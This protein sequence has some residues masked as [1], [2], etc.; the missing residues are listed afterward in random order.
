VLA[1][2]NVGTP[3][4]AGF[5]LEIRVGRSAENAWS[6]WLYM[7]DWGTPPEG[8]R[9]VRFERGRVDID[10]FRSDTLFDRVQYR[11]RATT[12]GPPGMLHLRRVTLCLSDLKTGGPVDAPAAA[13]PLQP[14]AWQRR[15]PVPFRTQKTDQPELAGK[16]CSPTSVA[17]VMAYYGV[18]RSTLDVAQACLDPHHGIYGNWPRNVQ[19]AYSFGVPGYLARFTNW[20][21]VERAIADGHPL[22]LSIRFAQPGIL[23]NSPYQATDGHLIVLAGFD[24]AG[25]VEVNDPAAT[26]PEKGCVWYPRA[27]LE[28]AWWKAT[29][30]VAYV[31]LPPE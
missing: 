9:V 16:I 22:I 26:T 21:D 30:G 8:E 1:S 13:R 11:V 12:A 23:L 4:D 14:P 6:P 27:G 10:Y 25:N 29:G 18:D 3:P 24:A 2:W 17:M 20:A 15:L 19:A 7:G 31:L 28:E 5:A